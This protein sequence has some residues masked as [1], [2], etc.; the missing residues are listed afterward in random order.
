L[1]RTD[2]QPSDGDYL[3]GAT[4]RANI[5]NSAGLPNAQRTD[6]WTPSSWTTDAAGR[7]L[8]V[9]S[10]LD[11]EQGTGL[12]DAKRAL[13][14]YDG[15]RQLERFFNPAGVSAIGWNTASI[16]G[17]FGEDVY[18]FNKTIAA[19]TFITATLTW[20]RIVDEMNAVGGLLGTVDDGDTYSSGIVPDFDLFIYKKLPGGMFERVAESSA[21]SGGGNVEHLHYP[22]PEGGNPFDYELRVDLLGP[23][24]IFRDYALSWWTTTIPEPGTC[25]L[26]VIALAA[27]FARRRRT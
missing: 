22:V 8:T 13:V 24:A 12:A 16:S 20:D 17:V 14:Q 26:T 23:G 2:Q 4:L 19:G 21:P 5:L 10:P 3:N 9:L 11:D 15:G 7:K 1:P 27:G 6:A 18:A 25:L